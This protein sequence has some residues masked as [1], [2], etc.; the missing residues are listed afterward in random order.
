MNWN[1]N[2]NQNR[3]RIRAVMNRVHVHDQRSAQSVNGVIAGT[4]CVTC[5]VCGAGA[6][7]TAL[8]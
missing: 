6:I 3:I 4:S 5:W 2:Q 1:R 8:Q 7:V